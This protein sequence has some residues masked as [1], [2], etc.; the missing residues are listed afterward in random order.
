MPS[1]MATAAT[2][3]HSWR[4]TA[5]PLVAVFIFFGSSSQ[6]QKTKTNIHGRSAASISRRA[7]G[8]KGEQ[9]LLSQF[10]IRLM[11]AQVADHL[12]GPAGDFGLHSIISAARAIL[13]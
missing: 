12:G 5:S 9:A 10:A 11:P 7:N 1:Q 6:Q 3:R 2:A 4:R 13:G 8:A